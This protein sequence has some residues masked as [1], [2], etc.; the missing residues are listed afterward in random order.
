MIKNTFVAILIFIAMPIFTIISW[1]IQWNTVESSKIIVIKTS[2]GNV[3]Y[4]SN[5]NIDDNFKYEDSNLYSLFN[6]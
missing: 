4:E 3:V 5:S 6:E 2:T 1:K